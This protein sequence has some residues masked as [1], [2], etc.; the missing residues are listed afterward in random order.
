[1]WIFYHLTLRWKQATP[2][3]RLQ[4]SMWLKRPTSHNRRVQD[5]AVCS[6]TSRRAHLL[7]NATVFSNKQTKNRWSPTA[8]SRSTLSTG[9]AAP[10]HGGFTAPRCTA[11]WTSLRVLECHGA[12]HRPLGASFRGDGHFEWHTS[13]TVWLNQAA[14]KKG[15]SQR[16]ILIRAILTWEAMGEDLPVA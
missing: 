4:K 12:S 9:L 3:P 16:E 2:D 14:P 7:I 8:R 6:I 5:S 13:V 11:I 15:H 10:D 1:M